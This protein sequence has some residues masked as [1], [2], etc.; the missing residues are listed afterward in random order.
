MKKS[1]IICTLE[2]NDFSKI[3][4]IGIKRV[5]STSK[6]K[7]IKATKKKWREKGRRD[8]LFGSN[9]HSN[10]EFISRENIFFSPINEFNTIKTIEIIM[11]IINKI[12]KITFTLDLRTL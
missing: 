1:Y 8:I 10:A 9:P 12:S 7:K 6:I 5:I 11:L 4:G 3:K 2:S